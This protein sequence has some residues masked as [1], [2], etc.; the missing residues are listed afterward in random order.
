MLL[1]VEILK[2]ITR[3]LSNTSVFE[4]VNT[5]THLRALR[6]FITFPKKIDD[7]EVKC[8]EMVEHLVVSGIMI[9]S[10]SRNL[11]VL[12]LKNIDIDMQL[13]ENLEK[14]KCVNCNVK[15]LDIN[16]RLKSC[17]LRYVSGTEYINFNEGLRVL[18]SKSSHS[19]F[20]CKL[21]VSLQVFKT[22]ADVSAV[23][24]NVLTNLQKLSLNSCMYNALICYLPPNIT[25]LSINQR[26]IEFNV[27]SCV[28]LRY[29][30][31][32]MCKDFVV[33]NTVEKFKLVSCNGGCSL[34]V[35]NTLKSLKIT[36]DTFPN[37]L[38]GALLAN[39]RCLKKLSVVGVIPQSML[40]S[41][42]ELESVKAIACNNYEEILEPV[43]FS[44]FTALKKIK[45]IDTVSEASGVV[46]HLACRKIQEVNKYT[47]LKFLC[48]GSYNGVINLPNLQSL[49]IS[50][51]FSV[52]NISVLSTLRYL[53]IRVDDEKVL[54]L[55]KL[56]KLQTLCVR[57][58]S[59]L[60]LM[61]PESLVS[62]ELTGSNIFKIKELPKGLKYLKS[63]GTQVLLKK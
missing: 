22:D 18:V 44:K 23:E 54:N 51:H 57:C 13:P 29:L 53:N 61:L 55:R 48:L 56:I 11:R 27:K 38:L 8:I 6:G 25:K 15:S 21:P 28:N 63:N 35:P 39:L 24:F 60:K 32:R 9:Y 43:N 45:V 58:V 40:K 14:L 10:F 16:L 30:K 52:K 62:L 17:V 31:L 33:P 34:T 49:E 50:E 46:E 41:C 12:T 36:C 47:T 1:P 2:V 42:P 26:K 59:F 3:F 4:F 19:Q 7:G 37:Y 20:T 5:C